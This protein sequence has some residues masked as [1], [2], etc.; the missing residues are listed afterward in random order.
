MDAA[1]EQLLEAVPNKGGEHVDCL[2]GDLCVCV[3]VCVHHH[4]ANSPTT[5]R[6]I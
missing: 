6:M 5:A 4:N 1:E 3:C 2:L